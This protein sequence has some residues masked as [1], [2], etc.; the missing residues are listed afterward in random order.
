[1]TVSELKRWIYEN[2]KIEYILDQIGCHHIKY[3]DNKKYYSCTNKD[4]DNSSAITVKNN[5]YLSCKNYTRKG[6]D[7]N[8][9]LIAL[10][11]FNLNYDFKESIKWLH[12][13]LGLKFT[14]KNTVKTTEEIKVDPLEVFKKVKRR[15]KVNVLDFNVVDENEII[16]FTPHIHI[17]WFREGIAPWTVKKFGLGYSYRHKRNVVPLRYWATGDLIGFTQRTTIKNYEEFDIPKYF[18]TPDYP[19]QMNIFG[20]WENYQNIL[21]AGYVVVYESEKSPLKRDSL[22]DFTGVAVSGHDI[23]D[24]QASILI[25]LNIVIIIAF[26]K[27]IPIDHVWRTC[28]KFYGIRPIY[29][30]YDK[31]DLLGDKDSPADARNQIFKYLMKYKFKYGFDEHS[32]YIRKGE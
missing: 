31:Y 3:H 10:V 6:F 5:E 29:Y 1:M 15:N 7:D 27:D 19:K 22:N 8:A 28:E 12:K 24:E 32:K 21:D 20:L 30:I 4:G 11:R 17:D 23:S 18:I 2:Q 14:Y 13:I 9:D 26:D 25:G 16:D